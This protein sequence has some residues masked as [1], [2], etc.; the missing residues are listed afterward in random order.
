M[1]ITEN[2]V[3]LRFDLIDC[4]V[5]NT[6][7]VE[8]LGYTKDGRETIKMVLKQHVNGLHEPSIV[9]SSLLNVSHDGNPKDLL[10]IL[11][12]PKCDT[13]VIDGKR[14]DEITMIS[15]IKNQ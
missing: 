9:Q 7:C 6:Y 12:E 13:E 8:Y 15:C 11:F 4:R 5:M 10:E 1:I 14:L 2:H 3:E